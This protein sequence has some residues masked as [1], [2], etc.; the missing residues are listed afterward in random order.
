MRK[1]LIGDLEGEI[2]IKN[3]GYEISNKGRIIGKKGKLL[4]VRKNWCGYLQCNVV[5]KDGFH[6]RSVHRAVAYAFISNDD[7]INKI[8]VNHKDGVKTNNCVEN[9]EWVTKKE[10]QN[11]EALVLKQK[12]GENN[13]QNKLTDNK[14]IEI[15]ELCKE[16]NMKY[17]DI[18]KRY[19]IDPSQVSRIATGF[20]WR[21]LGLPP[22]KKLVQGAR[23]RSK[24]VLWIN[25]NKEYTS[26]TT[27]SNDLRNTYGIIVIT[28]KIKEICNGNLD[29]W[30]GQKFKY[31]I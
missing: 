23:G 26:I 16:G 31:I 13:Y 1:E 17:K 6:A 29:E 21:H 5:F 8:E 3:N 7:P 18:A 10:N 12:G 20:E 25:E 22:L 15:Y 11:H 30:K 27:C 4:K 24:K 2:W 19:D 28:G 9:L 14:A